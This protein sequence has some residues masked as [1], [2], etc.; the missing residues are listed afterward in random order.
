MPVR[1]RLAHTRTA[2][3]PSPNERKRMAR[4]SSN[5]I[6]ACG[7]ERIHRLAPLCRAMHESQTPFQKPSPWHDF[8][9][10]TTVA[11]LSSRLPPCT[12]SSLFREKDALLCKLLKSLVFRL[13]VHEHRVGHLDQRLPRR[14]LRRSSNDVP[15]QELLLP[16][17]QPAL[18]G[19][20]QPP[21][22][23]NCLLAHVP[24][25]GGQHEATALAEALRLLVVGLVD[26]NDH[27]G[28]LAVTIAVADRLPNLL[29]ERCRNVV[30][31]LA[32]Q[33]TILVV[34]IVII[35]VNAPPTGGSDVPSARDGKTKREHSSSRA[36]TYLIE[37]MRRP[38]WDDALFC[39]FCAAKTKAHEQ[40]RAMDGRG[41]YLELP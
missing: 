34:V 19:A 39:N 16:G 41:S 21:D 38:S 3:S 6:T 18:L 12:P 23:R 13:A 24:L 17:R 33:F 28:C 5:G 15:K 11:V 20:A 40:I 27:A 36:A 4:H 1:S 14:S 26:T 32:A 35:V 25:G 9:S 7:P 22:E 8:P 30:N 29:A 31:T 2:Q 37:M 10:G